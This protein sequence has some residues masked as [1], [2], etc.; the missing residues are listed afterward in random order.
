LAPHALI[1]R[2][3]LLGVVFVGFF[4][5]W[6]RASRAPA[7]AAPVTRT[8]MVLPLTGDAEMLGR[9]ITAQVESLLTDVP[10]VRVTPGQRLPRRPH[11]LS[12]LRNVGALINVGT[13]LYGDLTLTGK[14]MRVTLRLGE[15]PDD[16]ALWAGDFTRDTADAPAL[17]RAIADSVAR[18]LHA[19]A[20]MIAL[21]PRDTTDLRT[22]AEH[23]RASAAF[24]KEGKV[25]EA[26][27]EARR[28]HELDPLARDIHEQYIRMLE[29]AGRRSEAGMQQRQ[30]RRITQYLGAP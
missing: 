16:S 15:L 22:A 25:A 7:G 24:E 19:A 29:R 1:R 8:M 30:L 6:P 28:A 11:T 27:R 3:L 13:V 20:G 26:L 21:S 5:W 10:G 23:A 2:A 18:T 17:A 4:L 14:T 12:D 9:R